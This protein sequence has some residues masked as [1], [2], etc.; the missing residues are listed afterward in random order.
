LIRLGS[1]SAFDEARGLGTVADDVGG[2][3]TF[4][5]TAIADGTRAV[6]VGTRVAFEAV[7]GHLGKM[8]ATRITKLAP[9]DG[10]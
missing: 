1:V 6:D 2:T 9:C 10:A 5:C 7:A 4:H 8:E 3:W